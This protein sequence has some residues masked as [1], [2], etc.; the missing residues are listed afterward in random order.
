MIFWDE[1]KLSSFR[2]FYPEPPAGGYGYGLYMPA[3]DRFLL[4][5][6]YDPLGALH[7]AKLLSGKVPLSVYSLPSGH[8]LT[9]RNCLLWSLRAKT[10]HLS[11]AMKPTL[12]EL[13]ENSLSEEGAP[14]DFSDLVREQEFALFV[15][16]A[17]YALRLTDAQCNK[18]DHQFF[19]KLFSDEM[20]N[21]PLACNIDDTRWPNGFVSAV[22]KILYLSTTVGQAK[23]KLA[24]LLPTKKVGKLSLYSTCFFSHLGWSPEDEK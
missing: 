7:A 21:L 19:L 11:E 5:D 23:E 12:C 15:W 10:V 20:G 14:A 9:N 24:K 8:S 6:P 13:E 2:K 1:H 17:S 18:S 22:E 3:V 16:R 4:V